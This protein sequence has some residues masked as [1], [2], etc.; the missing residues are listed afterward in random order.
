MA[1]AYRFA[2]AGVMVD[3][4][5]SLVSKIAENARSLFLVR[6][7]YFDLPVASAPVSQP[8]TYYFNELYKLRE[9][10]KKLRHDIESLLEGY[11]LDTNI[12]A[13][14]L[15][16]YDPETNESLEEN[17]LSGEPLSIMQNLFKSKRIISSMS[18]ENLHYNQCTIRG[19]VIYMPFRK[20]H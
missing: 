11:I 6:E 3:E 15:L 13:K 14:S 16:R 5:N 19:T 9:T 2:F 8:S 1:N 17:R 7:Q 12:P 20:L 10:L 4:R 18:E